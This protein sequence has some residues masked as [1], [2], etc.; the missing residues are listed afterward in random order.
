MNGGHIKGYKVNDTQPIIKRLE[1]LSD[2]IGLIVGDG[3]HSLASAKVCWDNLKKTL[4]E[5]ELENHPARYALV[6]LISLYDEGLTFEPIHRVLFNVN[7]SLIDGLKDLLEGPEQLHIFYDDK[8][9]VIKVPDNPFT[10]IK[11]IQ[12]YLDEYLE[13]NQEAE[14]DFIH[15]IK[16]TKQIV[17]K[18][19]NSI[20]ITMPPL[21]RDILLPYIR[22]HGVL[23]RKS[24]SLG[25]AEEK[26]YYLE[27]KR[28][29]K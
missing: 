13:K 16:N 24:F 15:G 22:E 1:A 23:P 10:T 14:I 26:R 28:I 29:L 3:N 4:P 7:H 20:G 6:E 18:N 8:E 17:L 27:G 2:D 11:I 25:E 21:K 19:K 12:D 5:S 9:E